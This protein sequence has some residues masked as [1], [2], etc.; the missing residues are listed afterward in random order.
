MLNFKRVE[1][2]SA[3]VTEKFKFVNKE[4]EDL[5]L[6][7][8]MIILALEEDVT[9]EFNEKELVKIITIAIERLIFKKESKSHEIKSFV[10]MFGHMVVLI[11]MKKK[12]NDMG[13]LYESISNTNN[14]RNNRGAT[15]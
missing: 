10:G 13:F 5:L 9:R 2:I 3:I 12:L 11:Y 15:V 4:H 7:V 6:D 1:A 8:S 14:E